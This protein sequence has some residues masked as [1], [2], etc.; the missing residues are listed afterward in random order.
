MKIE[1]GKYYTLEP[2]NFGKVVV[3]KAKKN[4]LPYYKFSAEKCWKIQN[5][6]LVEEHNQGY[7]KEVWTEE[8]TAHHFDCN[9]NIIEEYK[10]TLEEK[11][12]ANLKKHN[13]N[14]LNKKINWLKEI[15]EK[16][17]K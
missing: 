1:E 8:G 13:E 17:K 12:K 15:L 9:L 10:M 3:I 11:I 4:T 14:L 16:N 2:D 7:T 5:G 6:I